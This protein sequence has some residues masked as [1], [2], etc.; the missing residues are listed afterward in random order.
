[1]KWEFFGRSDKGE[2]LMGLLVVGAGLK[3]VMSILS[4]IVDP[5]LGV[6]L[7]IVGGLQVFSWNIGGAQIR[8]G[9]LLLAVLEFGAV[10]LIVYG[11]QKSRKS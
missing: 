5:I 3:V 2:L 7:G 11:W 10:V 8:W 1:M 6:L 4:D 9:G